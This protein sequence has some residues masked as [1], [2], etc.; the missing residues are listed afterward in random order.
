VLAASAAKRSAAVPAASTHKKSRTF[1]PGAIACAVLGVLLLVVG[2]A[3]L[4]KMHGVMLVKGPDSHKGGPPDKGD[5]LREVKVD[6]KVGAETISR[7]CGMKED[8]AADTQLHGITLQESWE[9]ARNAAFSGT[10]VWIEGLAVVHFLGGLTQQCSWSPWCHSA[11][12][13]RVFGA[14]LS[15]FW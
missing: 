8:V 4:I 11:G 15:S 9:L 2:L 7:S 1:V 12:L 6:A 10:Q 14:S 5:K 13:L 3:V